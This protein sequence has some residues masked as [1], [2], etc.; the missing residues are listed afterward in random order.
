MTATEVSSDGGIQFIA[1]AACLHQAR[2]Q[3]G[4]VTAEVRSLQQPDH[5]F[6]GVALVAFHRR[7]E[8]VGDGEVGVQGKCTVEGLLRQ[9]FIV[10][11]IVTEF[12][13]EMVGTTQADPCRRIIWALLKTLEIEIPCD[14]HIIQRANSLIW[15]ARR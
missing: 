6:S 13:Q 5:G 10:V 14:A 11:G 12:S 9:L 1:I 8:I 4:V 2:K 3:L 15:L 7:I